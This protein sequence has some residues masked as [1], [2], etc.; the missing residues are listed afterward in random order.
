[1]I[2]NESPKITIELS[3]NNTTYEKNKEIN[4]KILADNLEARSTSNGSLNISNVKVTINY[5]PE[6]DDIILAS[7]R[8][9]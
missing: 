4:Y 5:I 1:M 2:R 6:G 9:Q 3:D 8:H 7:I